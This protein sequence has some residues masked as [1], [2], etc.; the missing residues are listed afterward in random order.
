MKPGVRFCLLCCLLF[1]CVFYCAPSQISGEAS[2]LA[3]ISLCVKGEKVVFSCRVKRSNKIVSLC[4]SA[5]LTKNAGYLQ[6][7]FG[8]PGKTEL[9]FPKDRSQSLKLFK[10]S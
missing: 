10:W 6:Y 5:K 3:P 9:V 4:S 7:R 2:S 1:G 8:V